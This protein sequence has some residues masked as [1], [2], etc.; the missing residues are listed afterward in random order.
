M[1][2]RS[3]ERGAI[4]VKIVLPP[5]QAAESDQERGNGGTPCITRDYTST[6]S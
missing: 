5:K 3:M 2:F 6:A 4:K 1:D